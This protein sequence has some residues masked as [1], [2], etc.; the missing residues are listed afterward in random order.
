MDHNKKVDFVRIRV[1]SQERERVE[2][3]MALTHQK[4]S[5]I[6]RAA[7]YQYIRINHPEILD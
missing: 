3:I 4:R 5:E 7:I 1:S 6:Y 2:K